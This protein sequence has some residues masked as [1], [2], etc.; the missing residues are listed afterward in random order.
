MDGCVNKA[1]NC[2]VTRLDL[3]SKMLSRIIFVTVTGVFE[4]NRCD[5]GGTRSEN[6]HVGLLKDFLASTGPSTTLKQRVKTDHNTQFVC[7]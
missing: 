1:S 6:A 3:Y 5:D 7:M 4:D 2:D